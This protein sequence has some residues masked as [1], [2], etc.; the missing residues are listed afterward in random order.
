MYETNH[1]ADP[2]F[3]GVNRL[4][5]LS[6][7]NEDDRRSHSNYC[8]PKVEVKDY[9]VMIDMIDGKNLFDQPKNNDIKTY[10]NITKTATGQGDDH[11]T[12]CLLDYLY[13]KENYKMISIDLSK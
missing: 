4:F 7:E 11:A 3:Q 6:F 5:V 12:G 13:C 1:L 9:N 2:S 8:L 10:E